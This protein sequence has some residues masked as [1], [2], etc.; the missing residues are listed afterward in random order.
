M[1]TSEKLVYEAR[2]TIPNNTVA[3]ETLSRRIHFIRGLNDPK[4][5]GDVP[6]LIHRDHLMV[7][8]PS[9]AEP[10]SRPQVESGRE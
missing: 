3:M 7:N 2:M 9:S 10:C 8:A 1:M 6:M 4:A 5:I